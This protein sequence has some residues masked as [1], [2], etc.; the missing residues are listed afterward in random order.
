MS[1]AKGHKDHREEAVEPVQDSAMA[2]QDR[3]AVLDPARR[4]IQLS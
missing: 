1:K 3:P 2:G 4:F